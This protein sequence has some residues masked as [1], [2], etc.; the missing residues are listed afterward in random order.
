MNWFQKLLGKTYKVN[1]NPKSKEIHC[2]LNPKSAKCG[3]G[4]IKRFKLVTKARALKMMREDG[5]NGC[6]H[7]FPEFN[8]DKR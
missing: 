8:T 5:Y 3:A 6:S 1:L 7:C 2:L 4:L